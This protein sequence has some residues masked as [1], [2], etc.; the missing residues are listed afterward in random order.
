MIA[1]DLQGAWKPCC[2][3]L[4]AQTP[5]EFAHDCNQQ[6]H[7]QRECCHADLE[8]TTCCC[9]PRSVTMLMLSQ[10]GRGSR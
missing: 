9:V 1:D 10:L 3:C 6:L 7:R 2:A 5:A 4:L 8:S